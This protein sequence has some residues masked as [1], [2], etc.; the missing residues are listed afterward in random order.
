M[1]KTPSWLSDAETV[2][3]FDAVWMSG[4]QEDV[5]EDCRALVQS[6]VDGYNVTIFAYGQTGAG[7]TFTMHGSQDREG[8]APR[9]IKE[10][11]RII[12]ANSHRFN[13]T[14][15]AS[16]LELYH[17]DLI[18]LLCK[19]DPC[20]TKKK[21]AIRQDRFGAV[22]VDN[23]SEEQCHTA[24]ELTD[25]F[26]RGHRQRTVAATAMNSSSSRSHLVLIIRIASVD[27]E[28]H[29][30]QIGKLLICDLAGSERLKKSQA[31]GSLQKDAIAINKSLTALGDVIEALT[32]GN[33]AVPYR[34]HKLTQLLQDSLGGSA[35][36]LMLVN[37]SPAESSVHET[38]MTLKYAQRAKKVLRP[39]PRS[40]CALVD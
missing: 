23:L 31:Y 3:Q 24:A 20:V 32:K 39:S 37:C 22:V 30:R 25:V 29:R 1:T 10:I 14:V 8:L 19:G 40:R 15:T 2:F 34:N 26:S 36:T 4:T 11:Y 38:L 16:M 7:K 18:D 12:E 33:K 5:F 13:S 6:A 21:L 35:K 27:R 28:T 17:A 9:A